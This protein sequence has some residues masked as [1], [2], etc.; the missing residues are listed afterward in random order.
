MTMTEPTAT[1]PLV[2]VTWPPS[3]DSLVLG[4][5]FAS[6]L[7]PQPEPGTDAGQRVIVEHESLAAVAVARFDAAI[8]RGDAEDSP[9]GFARFASQQFDR[10][11]SFL[12][13]N[14]PDGTTAAG[15]DADAKNVLL[16]PLAQ[17][18]TAPRHWAK[19]IAAFIRPDLQVDAEMLD[20]LTSLATIWAG[21]VPDPTTFRYY[22]GTLFLKIGRLKLTRAQVE[23]AFQ[24]TL[25]RKPGEQGMLVLQG[26]ASVAALREHLMASAEYRQRS[27]APAAVPAADTVM[28]APHP[29]TFE[30][31]GQAF[32]RPQS[33]L[34]RLTPPPATAS[35]RLAAAQAA[36]A[37]VNA[38]QKDYHPLYGLGAPA[39]S[40]REGLLRETCTLI[41]REY[42]RVLRKSQIRI[43]DVGCNA[44]FVTFTLAET[45]PN[46]MGLDI[47]SDN[48]ALTDLLQLVDDNAADLESLDCVLFLNV[49]HQLIFARGIPYVK[50][51]LGHLSRH[52]DLLVVEL[53]RPADYVP[54]GL[55][56]QLPLDPAEILEECRDATITLVKDAKRP[57]Y[58]I[59]RRSLRIQDR[60]LPYSEVRFGLHLESQV[61]RK[62]YFGADSVTKVMRYTQMQ[63]P[64]KF[65]AEL[66]TL[67]ALAGQKVAPD[68]LAWDEDATM[69]RVAMNRLYGPSLVESLAQP[70]RS[71]KADLLREVIRIAAALARIGRC[72]ND[73]S[74]HNFILLTDGSLRMVDF[75]QSSSSFHR[76]PF[77]SFLWIAHDLMAGSGESY[78]LSD[79]KKLALAPDENGA[80]GERASPDAYPAIDHAAAA[81]DFD[82]GLAAVLAEAVTTTESWSSFIQKADSLRPMTTASKA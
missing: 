47:N 33:L 11:A 77:G 4:F 13:R 57:V 39:T 21:P 55:Q 25:G 56:D 44:G 72:Q 67:R 50:H 14:A 66:D 36:A 1:D 40:A 27:G 20:S 6:G 22:D 68:I 81:R 71:S 34:R 45:F 19:H 30:G 69:G 75:E 60:D 82:P 80:R 3:R 24:N 9:E 59:R 74:G 38:A 64:S 53:A 15:S 79:G 31:F 63:G 54:F 8:A 78:R 58:T 23:Q 16:V 48:I 43:L 5:A 46:T 52:V 41:E 61:N 76:D 35:Q 7:L 51:L 49:I 10:L 65:H 12:R 2:A 37:V 32:D 62:Y 18:R 42:A 73:F 29:E 28:D 70:K 26:F 17:M